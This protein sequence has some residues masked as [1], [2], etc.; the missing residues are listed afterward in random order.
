MPRQAEFNFSEK[1]PPGTLEAVA[2]ALCASQRGHSRR[3]EACVALRRMDLV[4]GLDLGGEAVLAEA[5]LR[6]PLLS[7]YRMWP[8][9]S[10][11]ATHPPWFRRCD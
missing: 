6:E 5:A 3:M 11:G 2:S 7:T 9:C 1:E 8:P 10:C 4:S